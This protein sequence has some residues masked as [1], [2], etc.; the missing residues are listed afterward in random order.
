MVVQMAM[1]N[2]TAHISYN[3]VWAISVSATCISSFRPS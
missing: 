1:P 2:V 3:S